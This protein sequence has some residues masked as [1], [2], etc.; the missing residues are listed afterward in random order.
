MN[1]YYDFN[2]STKSGFYANEC[3]LEM[4]MKANHITDPEHLRMNNYM[5][6]TI[7]QFSTGNETEGRRGM[8]FPWI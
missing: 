3:R 1:A 6:M 2:I 5:R 4:N 8:M 7:G